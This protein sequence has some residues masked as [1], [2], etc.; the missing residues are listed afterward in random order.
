[1]TAAFGYDLR[2]VARQL[3]Q[4]SQVNCSFPLPLFR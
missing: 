1:M 2:T 3:S 4:V